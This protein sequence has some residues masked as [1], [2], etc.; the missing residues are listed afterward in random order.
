VR[1]LIYLFVLRTRAYCS[2]QL[3]FFKQR[4][5]KSAELERLLEGVQLTGEATP[6]L[7]AR[8]LAMGELCS[9]H[10]GRAYLAR[11]LRGEARVSRV[12]ARELLIATDRPVEHDETRF[13]EADVTPREARAE[14][15]AKLKQPPTD[16][17]DLSVRRVVITQGFIASSVGGQTCLLGRGGSDTSGTLFAALLKVCLLFFRGSCKKTSLMP[18]I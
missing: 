7:R 5:N 1:S 11:E 15:F 13:L 10:I 8:A 9:S 16:D 14:A 6:R 2:F 18:F 12:D 4:R 17:G 3:I